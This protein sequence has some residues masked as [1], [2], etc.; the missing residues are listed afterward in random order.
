MINIGDIY[1]LQFYTNRLIKSNAGYQNIGLMKWEGEAQEA[2]YCVKQIEWENKY[3]T[4]AL[5]ATQD[6][7]F[8]YA[9]NK[10]FEK[11]IKKYVKLLPK[12]HSELDELNKSAL[13]HSI[14]SVLKKN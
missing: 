12:N 13:K 9:G 4:C 8:D 10:I 3:P 7:G 11:K 2:L 14:L 1:I 5:V 6:G